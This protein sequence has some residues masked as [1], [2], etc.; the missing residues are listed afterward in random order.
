MWKK[1]FSKRL[2]G[3]VIST[4]I[5]LILSAVVILAF[6]AM[7][8]LGK[9]VLNQAISTKTTITVNEAQAWY[10]GAND[11]ISSNP[12]ITA[13][14]FVTNL[15]SSPITVTTVN[16]L[17]GTSGG[18]PYFYTGSANQVVNPG[19]TISISLKLT[20]TSSVNVAIPGQ[21]TMT[22][23]YTDANGRTGSV[24]APIVITHA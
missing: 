1:N 11:L 16:I 17:A 14:F 9:I 23:Y 3:V 5:M 19:E 18:T 20:P 13:T 12:F 4:E 22:V 6:V 2:K 15:G 7:L 24:D 8:G 10:Y 21:T